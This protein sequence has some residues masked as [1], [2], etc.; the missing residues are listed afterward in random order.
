MGEYTDLLRGWGEI[1]RYLGLTR[2]TILARGYPVRKDGGVFAYRSELD[3]TARAK[4]ILRRN[5][6]AAD[7]LFRAQ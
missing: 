1:E 5:G 7:R 3:A 4:P 6:S 2:N